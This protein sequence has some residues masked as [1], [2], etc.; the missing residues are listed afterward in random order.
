MQSENIYIDITRRFNCGR[1]RTIISSGQAVVL[2]RIA[3]M[4]KDGDWIIREEEEAFE[5][6]LNILEEYGAQYRFGAPLDIRWLRGGWSSHFEF[7]HE[8]LRVRTDFVSR[9]P[10][11]TSEQL[12]RLWRKNENTEIPVVDLPLLAELKKTNREKDYVILGELARKMAS[13]EEQMLYSR[14]AR[15]L[16]D[17]NGRAP[18]L[19]QKLSAQR[20]LLALLGGR[21]DE[22]EKALDAERRELIHANERRLA[23]YGEA[24]RGWAEVWPDVQ[25][26]IASMPLKEAHRCIVSRAIENLPFVPEGGRHDG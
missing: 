13:L 22:I 26:D 24:A 7:R 2:Y 14:S 16:A 17:M 20:P 3:I 15:D 12:A 1:I 18:G 6:V 19:A 10:R 4:S 5:H 25:K 9:P 11:I 21:V 8:N 23:R